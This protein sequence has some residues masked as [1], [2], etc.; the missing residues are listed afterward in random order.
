MAGYFYE[1]FYYIYPPVFTSEIIRGRNRK[2]VFSQ[3]IDNGIINEKTVD[4]SGTFFKV[5]TLILPFIDQEVT[6]SKN[7]F[8]VIS[9][10]ALEK[11]I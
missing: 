10:S 8:A 9:E 5:K 1:E 3:L 4:N 11:A 7:R 2:L 6:T